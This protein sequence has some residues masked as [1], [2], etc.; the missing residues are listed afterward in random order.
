MG[1]PQC[2]SFSLLVAFFHSFSTNVYYWDDMQKTDNTTDMTVILWEAGPRL[3]SGNL[4]CREVSC[5]PSDSLGLNYLYKQC[6]WCST[7]V[8]FWESVISVDARQRVITQLVSTEHSWRW[9][10]EFPW[11]MT[12]TQCHLCW[13]SSETFPGGSACKEAACNAGDLGLIP[14][15]GRS[16]G[17]GKGYP[18]QYPGLENSMDCVV[19]RVVKSQTR[20]SNFHVTSRDSAGKE[21]LH[22]FALDL[23][24]HCFCL[25]PFCYNKS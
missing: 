24:P 25:V 11:Q 6:G 15:L 14:G 19:H 1:I 22:L 13:G 10:A 12:C 2:K 17:G 3:A 7:S 4:R 20:L 16:P 8:S 18:L 9:V 5:H 23:A 21:P